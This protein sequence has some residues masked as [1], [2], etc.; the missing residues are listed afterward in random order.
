MDLGATQ[1]LENL[2]HVGVL[3]DEEHRQRGHNVKVSCQNSG[4]FRLIR[5]ALCS[6]LGWGWEGSAAVMQHLSPERPPGFC[7]ARR[8]STPLSTQEL[9]CIWKIHTYT[10]EQSK[11]EF[12]LQDCLEATK[13][14]L[15]IYLFTHPLVYLCQISS[16][17]CIVLSSSMF[18]HDDNHKLVSISVTVTVKLIS[19]NVHGFTACTKLFKAFDNSH[20]DSLCSRAVFVNQAWPASISSK[21]YFWRQFGKLSWVLLGATYRLYP[22]LKSCT[23]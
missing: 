18:N 16:L 3:F 5:R 17:F 2:G 7:C 13:D 1:L 19:V 21:C 15:F 12:P 22:F 4:N 23:A 6:A 20:P 11:Q 9:G 14:D 8:C 10:W